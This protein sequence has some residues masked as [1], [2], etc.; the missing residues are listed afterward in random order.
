MQVPAEALT[1]ETRK[2]QAKNDFSLDM[3]MYQKNH[4]SQTTLDNFLNHLISEKEVADLT[5]GSKEDPVE[6]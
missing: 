1:L 5:V 2:R 4:P 3:I 6:G